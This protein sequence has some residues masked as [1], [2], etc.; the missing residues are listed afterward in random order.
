M[1]YFIRK[2]NKNNQI[3]LCLPNMILAFGN[4]INLY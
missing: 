2:N 3:Q 1:Q 4:D